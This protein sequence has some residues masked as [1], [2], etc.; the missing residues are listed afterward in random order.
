MT[1]LLI[2][3]CPGQ[4]SVQYTLQSGDHTWLEA[5]SHCE[6]KGLTL[7]EVHNEDEQE[8]L[9]MTL[10]DEGDAWIGGFLIY[11]YSRDVCK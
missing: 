4:T 2:L 3:F 8:Q 1:S 9:H 11:P 6:D 7:A 5:R 10:D